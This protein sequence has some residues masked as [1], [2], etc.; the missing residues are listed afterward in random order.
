MSYISEIFD[1]LDVQNI[2]EFLLHGV[3]CPASNPMGYEERITTAEKEVKEQIHRKY[4]E[5]QDDNELMD[6]VLSYGSETEDVYME[7]GLQCGF[8]LAM[9]LLKNAE[10]NEV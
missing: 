6:S 9:R 2:R 5:L 3:E 8:I 4:P 1:R 7:I 10:R